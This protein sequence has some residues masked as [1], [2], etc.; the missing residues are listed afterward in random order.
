MFFKAWHSK[1][2]FSSTYFLVFIPS[3]G[4]FVIPELLGGSDQIMIGKL[5]WTEFFRSRDWPF[6]SSL[7]IILLIVLTIPIVLL[8]SIYNRQDSL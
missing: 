1:T 3:F 6:A 5:L 8:K 2:D 7:A 4:E